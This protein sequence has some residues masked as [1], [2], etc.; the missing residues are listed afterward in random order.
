M[1]LALGQ[2]NG[3]DIGDAIHGE[4]PVFQLVGVSLQVGKAHGPVNR[5]SSYQTGAVKLADNRVFGFLR[6]IGQGFNFRADIIQESAHIALGRHAGNSLGLVVPCSAGDFLHVVHTLQC[7]AKALADGFF[8]VCCGGTPVF[9]GNADFR[10]Q[11]VGECFPGQVGRRKQTHRQNQNQQQVA[12]GRVAGKP[13][14]HGW[15]PEAALS[16]H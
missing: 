12:R 8:H 13:A 1:P 2:A 6:Q 15:S 16:S 9:H 10:W 4:K 14:D 7:F 11:V 5:D 3:N